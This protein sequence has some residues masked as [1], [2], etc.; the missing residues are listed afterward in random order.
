M[1]RHN[2]FYPTPEWATYELV[3][4]FSVSGRI[5]ECCSGDGAISRVLSALPDTDVRT[6]DIDPKRC[7]RRHDDATASYYWEQERQDGIDWVITN[8]PFSVSHLIVPQ[9]YEWANA[10]IAMLLRLSWL[11]PCLNRLPFLE[12]HPPTDLIVLPRISF[13]GDGKTDS[14]TCAWMVWDKWQGELAKDW[15]QSIH[16]APRVESAR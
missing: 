4:R 15:T 11:E 8:P 3:K 12:V 5:V 13:T 1:R 16:I 6:N 10:G 14:V 7:A 2:D 9:A